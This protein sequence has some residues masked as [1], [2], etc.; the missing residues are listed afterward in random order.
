MNDT[1]FQAFI[2]ELAA[3]EKEAGILGTAG[4]WVAKQ[5]QLAAHWAK[6]APGRLAGWAKARPGAAVGWAKKQP[7]EF[8]EAGKRMA[9]PH[10]SIPAGWRHMT[11]G[12]QLAHMKST[13]A[14]ADEIAKYTGGMGKHITGGTAAG[15]GRVQRIADAA[16][17]RGWSGKGDVTKY[18]PGWSQKGM[19]TGFG[20]MSGKSVYDAAKQD[21]S[22]TGSGGVA[23]TGLGEALGTGAFIAGTGGLGMIPA[24]AMWLGGQ[25]L[26]SRA[27]RVV[28]RMRG[29]ANLRTAA[30]APTPEE[31][32]KMISDVQNKS[33][34]E[35]QKTIDELRRYYG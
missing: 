11:P 22:R 26:G 2:D 16:S 17:R 10:K 23:E 33:P 24:S 27:G 9:Q 32:N 15:A 30:L 3:M 21:P 35:Q 5:P 31:A 1:T 12:K 13:G 25:F 28:D 19:Y 14:S 29:G 7:G 20:A 18:I 34:E 8:V 4:K 6:N